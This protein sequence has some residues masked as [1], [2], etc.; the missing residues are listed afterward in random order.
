ML[1]VSVLR[2]TKFLYV[3]F[4]S[5]SELSGEN[6]NDPAEINSLR[7]HKISPLCASALKNPKKRDVNTVKSIIE[8]FIITALKNF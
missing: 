1:P 8:F 4:V 6:E 7:F 5:I 3:S 2:I